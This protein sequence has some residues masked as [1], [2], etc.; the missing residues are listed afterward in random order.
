[1]TINCGGSLLGKGL[2]H[3]MTALRTGPPGGLVPPRPAV[4][5]R[6]QRNLGA[7]ER[8]RPAPHRD[9]SAAH[10]AAAAAMPACR[11]ERGS[12]RAAADARRRAKAGL[13]GCGWVRCQPVVSALPAVAGVA[14]AARCGLP[15]PGLADAQRGG[16]RLL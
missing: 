7:I 14:V 9:P 2:A 15:D 8:S 5:F 6:G 1:M 3:T 16:E 13:H 4:A 11:A 12:N 10:T